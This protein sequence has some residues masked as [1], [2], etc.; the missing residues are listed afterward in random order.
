[1]FNSRIWCPHQLGL[2]MERHYS[3]VIMSAMASQFTT[4]SIVCW[5]VCSG[6][7][8][9]KYHSCM[10]LAFVDSPHKGPVTWKM[11]PFDDVIM[12]I[13]L[14][15]SND[16]PDGYIMPVKVTLD[17]FQG[18]LLK[19]NGA[20]RISRVTWQLWYIHT[21]MWL[22]QKTSDS[23]R[24]IFWQSPTLC[25]LPHTP[26]VPCHHGFDGEIG[27]PRCVHFITLPWNWQ[28]KH[29]SLQT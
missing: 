2:S 19:I 3:N 11:F 28:M 12:W 18:A 20:P 15:K 26:S 16:D 27:H 22:L 4:V 5:T 13:K 9:R 1:M 7:D 6:V 23:V 24:P 8:Q 29:D 25:P 21:H 10:S 17:I 14:H